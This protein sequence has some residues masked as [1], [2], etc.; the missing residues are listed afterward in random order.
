MTSYQAAVGGLEAL[1]DDLTERGFATGLMRSRHP[2]VV[3]VNKSTSHLKETIYAAPTRDGS[4]WLWWSWAERIAAIDDTAVAAAK[5][6]HV[7]T[8]PWAPLTEHGLRPARA[9]DWRTTG[10]SLSTATG[11][12]GCGADAACLRE[13]SP[14]WRE[15]A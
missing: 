10:I 3:V 1:A 5:I 15:W 8:V 11:C 2:N 7:L 13:G 12:G 6:A 4:S 14:N 9:R